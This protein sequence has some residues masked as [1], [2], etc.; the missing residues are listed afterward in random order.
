M[1]SDGAHVSSSI[2]HVPVSCAATVGGSLPPASGLKTSTTSS[3][4]SATYTSPAAQS[5]KLVELSTATSATPRRPKDP[6][7]VSLPVQ[8]VSRL[9]LAPNTATTPS[10]SPAIISTAPTYTSVSTVACP[11]AMPY[12]VSSI[13]AACASCETKPPE[14]PSNSRS[15]EH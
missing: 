14:A 5:L 9:P 13:V 1:T 12:S 7:G 11:T 10:G 2:G 15:E 4:G 6:P 3:P 8:L